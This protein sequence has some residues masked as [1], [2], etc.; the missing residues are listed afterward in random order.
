MFA[1][2]SCVAEAGG[3]F[4][5]LWRVSNSVLRH[6]GVSVCSHVWIWIISHV[7]RFYPIIILAI[8]GTIVCVSIPAGK[9]HT[10]GFSFNNTSC[11]CS[12]VSPVCTSMLWRS[13]HAWWFHMGFASHYNAFL[14][15]IY[16]YMSYVPVCMRDRLV[17]VTLQLSLSLTLS[18]CISRVG[19]PLPLNLPIT[20]RLSLHLQP[21]P[22]STSIRADMHHFL[23]MEFRHLEPIGLGNDQ[24]C[25]NIPLK[26]GWWERRKLSGVNGAW[27]VCEWRGATLAATSLVTFPNWLCAAWNMNMQR[28]T[29]VVKHFFVID[30]LL[31]SLWIV[32]YRHMHLQQTWLP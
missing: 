3:S 17:T 11:V 30:R 18:P 21:S 16:I 6:Q 22:A 5:L 23:Q 20:P 10:G 27:R 2:G 28:C 31:L 8:G 26:V 14:S 29:G 24:K 15:Y 13:V 4:G 32:K 1:S 9:W 25:L 12:Q 19:P 7:S